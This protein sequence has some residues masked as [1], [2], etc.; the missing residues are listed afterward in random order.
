[1]VIICERGESLISRTCHVGNLQ[2]AFDDTDKLFDV[3]NFIGVRFAQQLSNSWRFLGS[4][5]KAWTSLSAR[6]VSV[7]S[8][9]SSLMA[10]LYSLLAG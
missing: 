1:M 9:R 8:I 5:D 10:S 2:S 7:A 6:L 4:L 3:Q